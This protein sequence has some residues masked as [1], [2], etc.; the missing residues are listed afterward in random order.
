MMRA[1]S[2]RHTASI[3]RCAALSVVTRLRLSALGAE[4]LADVPLDVADYFQN[5]LASSTASSLERASISA[6]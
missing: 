3:V 6:S 4:H 1:D 2:I 5:R